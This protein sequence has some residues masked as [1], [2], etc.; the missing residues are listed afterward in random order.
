MKLLSLCSVALFLG[1]NLLAQTFAPTPTMSPPDSTQLQTLIRKLDEQN[2]KIDTLSQQILKLEQQIANM[3]PGVMV[4]EATPSPTSAA[5]T[6]ATTNGSTTTTSAA[7]NGGNTHT[8]AR[9]ET[10]TSIAKMHSVSV[11]EL[12]KYNH[13]ENPLKLQAGQTIMIPA[14]P[15]PGASPSPSSSP[16]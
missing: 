13:I 14:S 3:R 15:A 7:P 5:S 2:V 12:Q 9:G 16:E 6:A 1:S 8:V 4:G 10:L 11:T